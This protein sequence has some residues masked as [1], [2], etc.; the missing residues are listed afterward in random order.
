MIWALFDESVSGFL[1]GPA[2]DESVSGFLIGFQGGLALRA[3][4]GFALDVGGDPECFVAGGI[5]AGEVHCFGSIVPENDSVFT[6]TGG[7][8]K[9]PGVFERCRS[10]GRYR[11]GDHV[12]MESEALSDSWVQLD[13]SGRKFF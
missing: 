10:C 6:L 11:E 1:V 8:H 12:I 2:L 9:V 5:G 7:A 13:G 3:E 4:V